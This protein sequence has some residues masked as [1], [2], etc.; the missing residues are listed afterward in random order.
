MPYL[1]LYRGDGSCYQWVRIMDGDVVTAHV[2]LFLKMLEGTDMKITET[3][4]QPRRSG[5]DDNGK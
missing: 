1:G 3:A 4:K 2:K 5:G